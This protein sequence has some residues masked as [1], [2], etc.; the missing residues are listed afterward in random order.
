M[1][2]APDLL[3]M[4]S[5]LSEDQTRCFGVLSLRSTAL[6]EPTITLSKLCNLMGC[7]GAMC[8]REI[9][10]D[11]LHRQRVF[12]RLL[13]GWL[14]KVQKKTTDMIDAISAKKVHGLIHRISIF[15]FRKL[16][17]VQMQICP[18]PPVRGKARI[19]IS[20]MA[21][22]TRWGA[23]LRRNGHRIVVSTNPCLPPTRIFGGN[24]PAHEKDLQRHREMPFGKS[25]KMYLGCPGREMALR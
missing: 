16:S 1:R 21:A 12:S 20:P 22:A 4:L 2:A 10:E 24:R 15:S 6:L 13:E 17:A 9:C 7:A 14:S 11:L 3:S 25:A 8:R 5:W 19:S 23:R 18:P